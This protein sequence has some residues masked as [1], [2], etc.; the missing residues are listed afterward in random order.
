VNTSVSLAIS[1]GKVKTDGY[2]P[3]ICCFP[4]FSAIQRTYSARDF[5]WFDAR[6]SLVYVVLERP[7]G[8]F[9]GSRV[10]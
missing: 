2:R 5:R 3:F 7:Q 1:V 10:R 8:R 6:N 9:F 4:H